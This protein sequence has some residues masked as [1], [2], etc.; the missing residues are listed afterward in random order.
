MTLDGA[1]HWSLMFGHSA[2]APIGEDAAHR[3]ERRPDH[4][5]E[6]RARDRQIDQH[7]DVR[8]ASRLMSEPQEGPREAALHAFGGHLLESVLELA[9]PSADRAERARCEPRL[10][11]QKPAHRR[12]V[13]RKHLDGLDGLGRSRIRVLADEWHAAEELAGRDEAHQRLAA[14]ARRLRDLHASRE[15]DHETVGRVALVE[16]D[17]SDGELPPHRKLAR[18]LRVL[19]G[20]H[21]EDLVLG[22]VLIVARE[23]ARRCPA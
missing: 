1:L 11:L 2:A 3:I 21:A 7:S 5:G 10:T 13:P 18:L 20:Q 9:E 4:V 8:A 6:L 22:H 14:I 16:E 15:Q 12:A 17:V 19:G 23:G